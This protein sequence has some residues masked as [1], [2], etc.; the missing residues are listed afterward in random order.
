MY[1][2]ILD[3]HTVT[4]NTGAPLPSTGIHILIVAGALTMALG[5]LGCCGAVRESPSMLGLVSRAA[6][7]AA[8]WLAQFLSSSPSLQWMSHNAKIRQ[9]SP[10]QVIEPVIEAYALNHIN[11]IW[12]QIIINAIHSLNESSTGPWEIEFKA[13]RDHKW[14]KMGAYVIQVLWFYS[15]VVPNP[16]LGDPVGPCF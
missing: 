12:F 16:V 5:F 3:K 7:M 4:V 15:G 9:I 14:N 2:T 13:L 1:C 10:E 11:N 6:L 8:F